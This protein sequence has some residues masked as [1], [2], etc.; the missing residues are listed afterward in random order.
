MVEHALTKVEHVLNVNVALDL[1]DQIAQ[2]LV[3]LANQ[4]QTI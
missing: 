2:K 3:R 4:G 1:K